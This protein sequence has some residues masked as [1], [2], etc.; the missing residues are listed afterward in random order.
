MEP[1][2]AQSS[3]ADFLINAGE[4]AKNNIVKDRYD[5]AAFGEL[6]LASPE[7]KA[8]HENGPETFPEL[9]QD[10]WSIFFKSSPSHVPADQVTPAYQVNRMFTERTIEDSVTKETRLTTKLDE[11]SSAVATICAGKQLLEEIENRPDLKEAMNKAQE[12]AQHEQ[13]GNFEKSELLS[14]A[15]QQLMQGAAVD[16]RRAIKASVEKGNEKAQEIQGTLAGWGL[17]TADLNRIPLGERLN[18]V[19]KLTNPRMK[20]VAN[21]VGRFRNLA[22]SR[23]K[24]KLKKNRDEIHGVTIGNDLGRLLPAELG[25]LTHPVRKLDFY[26]KFQEKQLLQYQLRTNEPQGRGPIIALIDSS[27]S[28]SGARMDWASAVALALVDTARRQKRRAAVIHFNTRVLQEIEFSPG[29]KDVEKM[30]EV[31]TVNASGGTEYVPP[32]EKA[33]NLINTVNY[34]KADIVI[35][36]DGACRLPGNFISSLLEL[37]KK[38]S[39]RC[40]SVLINAD[41][42]SE[43]LSKW[44]NQVWPLYSVTDDSA[45]ETAG[46]VFQEVY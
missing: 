1:R 28:M 42:P 6:A 4:I 43:E 9:T 12:A 10:I 15:A 14:E 23:Q 22:R 18:L 34:Q 13:S 24:E 32:M 33:I 46:D 37:K 2:D 7:F 25:A 31:A 45:V 20:K 29:E 19:Q 40:W 11:L 41:D 36:T 35:V 8:L 3:G 21:L 38:M 17:E 16:V 30:A 44:C 27:G 39:F 5:T 26:R